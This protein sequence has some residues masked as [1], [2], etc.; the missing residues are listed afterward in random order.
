VKASVLAAQSALL[1]LVA[2]LALVSCS[3]APPPPAEERERNLPPPEPPDP[4]RRALARFELANAYYAQGQ[5][6]TALDEIKRSLASNATFGPAYNLRGLIL[7]SL[8]DDAQADESFRRA[9]QINPRDPDAM[10][11]YGW[12][13]CQRQ[14]A[15][16]AIVQFNQALT[17]PQYRDAPR[18]LAARG[19]CQA[20]TG[21][22][23]EA[24]ASLMRS[25]ELDPTNPGTALNLSDVLLRRGEL[26]RARFY[27]GRVNAL[28]AS[29]N[30]QTLWLAARIE[31]KMGNPI[32][33]RELG[34]RIRARFPQAPEL[35]RFDQGRF[36]E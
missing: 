5:F 34:E 33:A 36:D 17:Q 14:R 31:H 3:S 2:A 20:R 8:G 28:P 7:A 12:F 15:P 13:L 11:N 35:L 24:E 25:Y 10:H 27:I 21:Q 1:V 23:A 22:W 6:N 19:V 26:T 32:A 30:A 9:L 29:S 16:E 4:E 18:T